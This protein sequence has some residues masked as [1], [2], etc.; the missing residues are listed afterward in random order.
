LTGKTFTGT[1]SVKFNG[2]VVAAFTV[3][4]GGTSLNVTVPNAAVD[5]PIAVTNAGGTTNTA[6]PFKV[7]PKLVSFA[8]LAAVGGASVPISGTG[9]GTSPLVHFSGSA[10][11][12]VLG[13]HTATSILA[14]VPTDARNGTMTVSTANG[15]ATS[16]AVF[17]PLPKITGFGAAT[18]RAGDTVTVNGSNFLA[19]GVDPTAKLGLLAVSP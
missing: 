1:S 3:G 16:V 18:Y 6:N 12:A 13:V 8:P 17:K 7:D 19:T 2:T 15:D 11:P 4:V 14:V 10:A 5:G 9:F